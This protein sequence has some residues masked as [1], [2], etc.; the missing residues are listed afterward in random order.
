MGK[1][2]EFVFVSINPDETPQ[3]AYLKKKNYIQEYGRNGDASGWHFLTGKEGA[4]EDLAKAVGWRYKWV[5][6]KSQFAHPAVIMICTPD[7]RLSR[8]L[9]GVKFPEQTLRLSLVDASDGKIGTTLDHILLTCCVF[10][11]ST[12]RYTWAAYGLLR[13]AGI[14]T[15]LAVAAAW[16]RQ[17][18]KGRKVASE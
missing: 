11:P 12:G 8:Y 13:I 16:W 5:D 4:I 1:D 3:M 10:D 6:A 15:M 9:Y 18:R 2:Y 17:W 14:I 7:G